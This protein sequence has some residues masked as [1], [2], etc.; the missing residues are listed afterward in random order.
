VVDTGFDENE[1]RKQK[2]HGGFSTR[3]AAEVKRAK[4]VSDLQLGRICCARSAHPGRVGETELAPD[5]ENAGE[6]VHVRLLPLEPGDARAAGSREPGAAAADGANA[7]HALRRALLNHGGE[8]GPLAPKTVRYIHTIV[9]KALADAIDAGIIGANVAE[10]AK[11][12]RPHRSTALKIEC[13]EPAELAAFLES[14]KGTRLEAAWRL[15]AMTGRRSAR[16]PLVRCRPRHLANRG[17]KRDRLGR[18]RGARILAQ[19]P[20]GASNRSGDG[21]PGLGD[22]KSLASSGGFG[23]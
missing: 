17:A 13:W 19:E 18:L 12:P 5:D 4:I 8:R 3:R 22:L 21:S 7:E 1:R 14:V 9:H 10:R 2:W 20:P 11:P 23:T 15:A 16:A 6:A